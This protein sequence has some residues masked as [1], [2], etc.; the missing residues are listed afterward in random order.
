MKKLV[1]N[2]DV[3]LS[4]FYLVGSIVLSIAIAFGV[5]LSSCDLKPAEAS[6]INESY[7]NTIVNAIYWA[8]G[9]KN[10][11]KPFGILSVK[12]DGYEDCRRICY[13]TVRNNWKRYA[14]LKPDK[15]RDILFLEYLASRYAPIGAEN[16]PKGYNR[17]WMRNVEYFIDHPK[18]I[19]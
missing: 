7:A 17:N 14:D 10:A 19:K 13:N 1:S 8:E 2:E 9:G 12:C 5:L 11:K 15:K 4:S 16:D 6:E 3:V 18:E